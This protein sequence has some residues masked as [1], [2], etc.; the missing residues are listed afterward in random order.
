MLQKL[1][2]C[3]LL[4]LEILLKF[5]PKNGYEIYRSLNCYLLCI[6]G[7]YC[8]LYN[9]PVSNQVNTCYFMLSY[10]IT[11]MFYMLLYNKHRID[12]WLHHLFVS[13]AYYEQ[14]F[15]IDPKYIKLSNM[16]LL[17]ES[18]SVFNSILK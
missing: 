2:I 3:Q 8:L 16:F 4:L 12:L 1:A 13:I 5:S 10:L 7:L 11:D 17:A 18:L 9:N 14:S 6:R 15:L